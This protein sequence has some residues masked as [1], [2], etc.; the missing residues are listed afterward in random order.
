MHFCVVVCAE[1]EGIDR[2]CA[3]FDRECAWFVQHVPSAKQV[4]RTPAALQR[5]KF[6]LWSGYL[7]AAEAGG[8]FLI[9][10]CYALGWGVDKDETRA[11]QLFT[12]SADQGNAWG[13]CRLGTC[14]EYDTGVHGQG[15]E[16]GG[17][18]LHAVGGS[19]RCIGAKQPRLLYILV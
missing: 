13:Q 15:R 12:L 7:D 5:E 2:E 8:Q 19:R 10:R 18:A 11:F 9:G 17:G 1:T 3:W 16:E 4:S 14:Y 6:M